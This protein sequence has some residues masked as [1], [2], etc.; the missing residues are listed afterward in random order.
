MLKLNI[1]GGF[2]ASKA[3]KGVRPFSTRAFGFSTAI[4]AQRSI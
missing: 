2:V 4:S 1:V 3:S